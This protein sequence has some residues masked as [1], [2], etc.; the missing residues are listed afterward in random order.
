MGLIHAARQPGPIARREVV[1]ALSGR[2][3]ALPAIFASTDNA[4]A[5]VTL[6]MLP[7]Y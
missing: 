5:L 2:T 4:P 3:A 1:V 7:D 6:A